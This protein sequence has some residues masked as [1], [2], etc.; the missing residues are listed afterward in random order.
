MDEEVKDLLRRAMKDLVSLEVTLFFH[1]HPEHVDSQEGLCRRLACEPAA[2]ARALER[3]A[4]VGIVERF[5]LGGGRYEVYSYTHNPD[6]RS[7][8]RR[9]SSYYHDD[10]VSR[11]E[12][13]QHII[14]SSLQPPEQQDRAHAE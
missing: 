6:L 10:P 2:I 11:A 13:I 7:A 5:Q 1:S 14:S 3:L 12:I 8:V 9:L 4:Q